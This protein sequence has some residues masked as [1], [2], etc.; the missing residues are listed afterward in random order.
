MASFSEQL[1]GFSLKSPLLVG[2]GLDKELLAD[3]QGVSVE[4]VNVGFSIKGQSILKGVN[5]RF[6]SGKVTALMGPSGAGKTTLL[7]LL[8]GHANDWVRFCESAND[9]RGR[10]FRIML[11]THDDST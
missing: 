8:S 3:Q 11:A 9:P 7:S 5:A 2:A 10:R 4:L 6:E 1:E